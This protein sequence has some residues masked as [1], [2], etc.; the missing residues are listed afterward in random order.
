MQLHLALGISTNTTSQKREVGWWK[1]GTCTDAR[2]CDPRQV[3]W[4]TRIPK[5]T[6]RETPGAAIAVVAGFCSGEA[7]LEAARRSCNSISTAFQAVRGIVA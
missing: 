6:E 3:G 7:E 4:C 2:T 1:A 5:T